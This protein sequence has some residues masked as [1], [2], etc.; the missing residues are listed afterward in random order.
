MGW[1]PVAHVSVD[2]LTRTRPI[3]DRRREL[4]CGRSE[5][6]AARGDSVQYSANEKS[7]IRS[8]SGFRI[9]R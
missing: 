6:R 1:Q 9:V 4:E 3:G 8:P 7:L 2:L 5:I